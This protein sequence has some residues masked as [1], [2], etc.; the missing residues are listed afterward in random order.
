MSHARPARGQLRGNAQRHRRLAHSTLLI[1]EHVRV[2]P[3]L[4]RQACIRALR[5]EHGEVGPL[6]TMIG[7]YRCDTPAPLRRQS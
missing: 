1:G 3:G 5:A 7:N 2:H 4:S 6:R